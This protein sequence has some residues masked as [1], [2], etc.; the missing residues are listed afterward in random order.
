MKANDLTPTDY[1]H[2]SAVQDRIREYCGASRDSG[3]TCEFLSQLAPGDFP[4]WDHAPRFEPS[5]LPALLDAGW[6]LSRSLLDGQSLIVH[7]EVDYC[8][9]EAPAEALLRPAHVFF[10][11]EP[12]YRTV[13]RE[14]RRLELP[15]LDVMSGRGFHFTGRIPLQSRVVSRL[16]SFAADAPG[17]RRERA[18]IGLGMAMEYFTQS[19]M[20]AAAAASRIPVVVNGTEVGR[21]GVGREAAS[22]DL[23]EYGDPLGVRQ[24]RVAFST[25]QNHRIR[26]DVFGRQSSEDVPL[27]VTIPRRERPLLWMLE[28]AR[29]AD[30]AAM[31]ARG[32]H[33]TIPE[34]TIGVSNLLDDY[35]ASVLCGVHHEYYATPA[36]GP[37]RW[38][39]TYDRLD[40]NELPPCVGSALR[41]PNDALLKPTVL[42]QLTRCLL[43]RGW[44]PRH[45]AGLVWSKYGRDHGW[46]DRWQRLD[47][48]LRAD[49]DV[50]VFA[51][52]LAT[53]VDKAMDFNCVSSQEKG[54][55]PRTGCP[56][57]LRRDQAALLEKVTA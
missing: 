48:A 3:M 8:N 49:F 25:Y 31:I 38:S 9:P 29:R 15:L 17:R 37:D 32:E 7:L 42:Q 6:D 34:A 45:I 26:P 40:T 18:H 5:R 23:S 12:V 50:R 52:L 16:S 33:A 57:D 24:I 41:H 21:G 4:T 11:L 30:Q 43:A 46:G 44:E 27:L 47:P 55:C 54:L 28:Y 39:D 56:Y 14:L 20:H 2:D 51:G 53:G 1:Y 13:M 10:E 19:I 35:E 22:I 36:H